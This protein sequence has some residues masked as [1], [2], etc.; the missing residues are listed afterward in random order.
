MANILFL[1]TISFCKAL[2]HS[3]YWSWHKIISTF[4]IQVWNATENNDNKKKYSN[5]IFHIHISTKLT[6][7]FSF[8]L[9][10]FVGDSNFGLFN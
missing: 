8:T 5:E 9:R 1:G 6:K 10:L 7:Y 2:R 3:R 4:E